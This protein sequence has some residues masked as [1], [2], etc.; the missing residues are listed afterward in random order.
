MFKFFFSKIFIFSHEF[1]VFLTIWLPN[2]RK[3]LVFD[4]AVQKVQHK[5]LNPLTP[6]RHSGTRDFL[7]PQNE[8]EIINPQT[9]NS[10]LS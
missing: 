1:V 2:A 8:I 9:F 5:I 10:N 7:N 3:I 6:K 4:A